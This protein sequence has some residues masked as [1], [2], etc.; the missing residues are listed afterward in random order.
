M[1]KN[2]DE[3]FQALPSSPHVQVSILSAEFDR[4]CRLIGHFRDVTI[5]GDMRNLYR[6]CEGK[7]KRPV[8][9]RKRR[10]SRALVES[11]ERRPKASSAKR[12][13]RGPSG[14]RAPHSR[15]SRDQADTTTTNLLDS[16]ADRDRAARRRDLRL[17]LGGG[18]MG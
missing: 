15:P 12:A 10:A 1:K 5:K 4:F 9:A 16:G 3:R 18:G 8:T 6:Q 14:L 11:G 2:F 13:L 7:Q 17:S